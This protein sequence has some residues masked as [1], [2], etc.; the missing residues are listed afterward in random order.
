MDLTDK[1]EMQFLCREGRAENRN[2]LY[3]TREV[4]LNA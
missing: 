3:R 2:A 1:F 4:N